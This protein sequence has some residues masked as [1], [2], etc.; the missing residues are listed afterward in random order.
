V[1]TVELLSDAMGASNKDSVCVGDD[2]LFFVGSCGAFIY[3]GATFRGADNDNVGVN[4]NSPST[5]PCRASHYFPVTKS[6]YFHAPAAQ[7]ATFGS[8]GAAFVYNRASDRW[9]WCNFYNSGSTTP[10]TTYVMV[11]GDPVALD[12]TASS[13]FTDEAAIGLVDLSS[14]PCVTKGTGSWGD[15]GSTIEA[16]V[17]TGYLG[18]SGDAD[19]FV[20]RVTPVLHAHALHVSAGV[21]TATQ[22][23]GTLGAVTSSHGAGG[24]TPSQSPVTSSTGQCRFDFTVNSKFWNIQVGSKVSRFEIEDIVIDS[25]EQGSS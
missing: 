19:Q 6:V 8:A 3:D 25:A 9:G 5:A 2:V 11:T 1:W 12:A 18:H 24:T 16:Y 10:L 14:N 20:S 23:I 7:G 17:R 15:Q 13:I 4:V 21:P 22:L